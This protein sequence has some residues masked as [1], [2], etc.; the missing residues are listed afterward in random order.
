MLLLVTLTSGQCLYCTIQECIPAL[1]LL[2]P[3]MGHSSGMCSLG[4]F[5]ALLKFTGLSLGRFWPLSLEAAQP[6]RKYSHDW[7]FTG[8]AWPPLCQNGIQNFPL[9]P[10]M[11]LPLLCL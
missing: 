3:S 4:P 6:W 10:V 1:Q 8:G 7:S 11:A 9:D 5:H 2:G